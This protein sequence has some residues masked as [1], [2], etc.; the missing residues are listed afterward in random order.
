MLTSKM[1]IN[2]AHADRSRAGAPLRSS[3]AQC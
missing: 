3:D 2:L 1:N